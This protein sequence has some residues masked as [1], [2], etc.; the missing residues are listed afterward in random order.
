M[1]KLKQNYLVTSYNCTSRYNFCLCLNGHI[2]AYG[3]MTRTENPASV[4]LTVTRLQ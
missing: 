1:N 4:S 2:M 3:L